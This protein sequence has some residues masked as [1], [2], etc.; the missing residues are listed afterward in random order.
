LVEFP[1]IEDYITKFKLLRL[2]LSDCGITKPDDQEIMAILSKLKAPFDIFVSTFYSTRDALG[3]N[4]KMPTFE[5]FCEQLTCEQDK[6]LH[7]GAL[8][9]VLSRKP[10]FLTINKGSKP[11]KK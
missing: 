11:F 4:Y 9:I 7:M 2:Q 6:L 1:Q 8:D 5:L 3:A 10:C